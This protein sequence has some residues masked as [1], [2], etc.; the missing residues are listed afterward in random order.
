MK[1]V[2]IL[3]V[4]YGSKTPVSHSK[5]IYRSRVFENRILRRIFGSKGEKV[6]GG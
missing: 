5:K 6:T 1:L 3:D 2:T 4:L